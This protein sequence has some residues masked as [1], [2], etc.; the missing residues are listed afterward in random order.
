MKKLVE[1]L[2]SRKRKDL[3]QK[4]EEL[5]RML[6]ENSLVVTIGGRVVLSMS[7]LQI[8]MSNEFDGKKDFDLRLLPGARIEG[9]K[10]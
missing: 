7:L 4:A 5:A 9:G 3:E 10:L 8:A 2:K 6:S 1:I